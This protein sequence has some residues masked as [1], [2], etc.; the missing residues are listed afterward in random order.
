MR[1]PIYS[2]PVAI[3]IPYDGSTSGLTASNVQDAIDVAYAAAASSSRG[4]II[5]GFDG[6]ASVGRYLEFFSNNPSNNNPFIVAENSQLVALSISA[7]SSSTGTVTLFVN[8]VSTQ[9]ISLAAATSNRVSGLSALL[10]PGNQISL[11]VTSGSISRPT[12]FIFIRTLPS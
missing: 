12:V 1:N 11:E 8:G 9:T 2:S 3:E 10:T 7:S 5:C 6:T 4:A